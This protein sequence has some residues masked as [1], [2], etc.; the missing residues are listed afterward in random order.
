[1]S[2]PASDEAGLGYVVEQIEWFDCIVPAA[3]V[4]LNQDGEVEQF[5]RV[6]Q[7]QLQSMLQN[8]AFTSEAALIFAQSKYR[9][10]SQ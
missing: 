8:N 2:M 3:L 7:A 9:K 1:M 10:L 5:K 6:P 4:P